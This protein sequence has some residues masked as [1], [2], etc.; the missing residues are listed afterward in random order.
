M[1]P[2]HIY[3][4]QQSV[5]TCNTSAKYVSWKTYVG[6]GRGGNPNQ[7]YHMREQNTELLNFV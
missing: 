2:V 5:F 3:S 1:I 4:V 6:G 7:Q